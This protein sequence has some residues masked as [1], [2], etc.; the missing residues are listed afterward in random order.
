MVYKAIGLMSGSS[1]DGLDIVFTELTEQRGKWSYE[2]N[3]AET[4]P[5]DA[6]WKQS[7]ANATQLSAFDYLQL[8]AAYGKYL[9]EAVSAFISKY[10]LHHQVQLICSHGH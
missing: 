5:Y 1:L 7:L 6:H 8:H 2:I 3:A 9:G 4:T 10:N